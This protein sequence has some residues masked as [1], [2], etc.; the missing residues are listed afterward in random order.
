M[1]TGDLCTSCVHRAESLI[2]EFCNNPLSTN[3]LKTP[4]FNQPACN[5]ARLRL[6][7]TETVIEQM[8]H[9]IKAYNKNITKRFLRKQT[10]LQLLH[11]V[12]EE[13]RREF[14]IALCKAHL[15]QTDAVKEYLKH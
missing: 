9:N 10:P 15:C 7:R 12:H 2:K 1:I 5:K 4:R 14:A 3:Y 8:H 13:D 6:R 11:L